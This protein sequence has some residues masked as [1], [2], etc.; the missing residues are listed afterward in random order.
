MKR[1]VLPA[2]FFV[3]LFLAGCGSEQA[4]SLGPQ[5]WSDLEF[6]VEARPTPIRSGM[7]E[8]IVIASREKVKPGTGI[9]VSLRLDE[10]AEWTQAIQDG[11]TGVYRRAVRVNNP[12]TDI[13]AVHVRKVVQGN[14][15]NEGET[16][17][18]F[19][20]NQKQK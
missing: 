1:P 20:L 11:F 10:K 15:G 3:V 14:N 7:T 13:L 16:I 18:Y 4:I 8:F 9:V 17:L 5:N 12:L 6:I 2:L 19:P